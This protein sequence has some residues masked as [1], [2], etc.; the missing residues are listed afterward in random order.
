MLRGLSA[1]GGVNEPWFAF[2]V[3]GIQACVKVN[4]RR[5][6]FKSPCRSPSKCIC[7]S[8]SK[9]TR[10]GLLLAK[11][12]NRC[13]LRR[14]ESACCTSSP[15]GCCRSKGS[16]SSRLCAKKT[17]LRGCGVCAE[18]ALSGLLMLL[19]KGSSRTEGGRRILLRLSKCTRCR[20]CSKQTYRKS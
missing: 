16:C 6:T 19:A 8:G 10:R 7:S 2:V 17:S 4:G 3:V 15:K 20:S 5:S 12:T 14:S 18:C 9:S 1:R 11:G 13:G